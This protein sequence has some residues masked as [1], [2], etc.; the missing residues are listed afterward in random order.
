MELLIER[1]LVWI[2]AISTVI[3][4]IRII[5]VFLLSNIEWVNDVSIRKLTESDSLETGPEG[6]SIF[7]EFYETDPSDYS[8]AFLI[9]PNNE[10]IK[11]MRL[12]KIDYSND[13]KKSH[14]KTVKVEKTRQNSS[15]ILQIKMRLEHQQTSLSVM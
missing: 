14:Y 3:A 6:D 13:Y 10:L 15:S 8:Q 4:V 2:G 1:V 7:P 9:R 12:I 5:W 11:K